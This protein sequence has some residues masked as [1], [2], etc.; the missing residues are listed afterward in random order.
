MAKEKSVGVFSQE[1]ELIRT[2]SEKEQGSKFK[3]LAE[4][5]AK[6][7]CCKTKEVE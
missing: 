6:K 2:Y 4:E 1:G 7:T 5:F 3:S